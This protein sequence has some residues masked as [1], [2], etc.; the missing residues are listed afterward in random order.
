MRPMIL[1]FHIAA[2]MLALG[3][4][5]VALFVTKG[6]TAHRRSSILFVYAMIVMSLSGAVMDALKTSRI[7]INVVAGLL[8][9]YFVTTGLLTVRP[10]TQASRWFD[11]VGLVLVLIVSALAF[12]AGLEMTARHNAAAPPSFLFCVVGL[13]AAAG[14]FRLLRAG[15]IKGAPRLKRHLWRMCFGMWVAAASFFWGP[16]NRVPKV[17]RIPALQATAVLIPIAVMIYWLW[18]LRRRRSEPAIADLSMRGVLF[19]PGEITG[20]S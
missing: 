7:S 3:L 17:I 10:R 2:G 15:G 5:Y 4:G 8:T 9:F 13:L 18:R 1:P 19:T 16:P 6:L 12:R 14:D 11:R 20:E